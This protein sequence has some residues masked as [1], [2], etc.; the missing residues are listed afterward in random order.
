MGH[1][2]RSFVGIAALLTLFGSMAAAAPTVAAETQAGGPAV[3]VACDAGGDLAAALAAAPDG[4]ALRVSGHCIGRFTIDKALDLR[5]ERTGAVLDGGGLGTTLTISAGGDAEVSGVAIKGGSG[6]VTGPAPST[7]RGGGVLVLGRLRLRD[8]EVVQNT[9]AASEVS[10]IST[11]EGAGIWNGGHLELV[12]VRIADNAA[13]AFDNSGGGLWN[14]GD[15]DIRG[16]SV[17]NNVA[18]GYSGGG[19]GVFNQYSGMLRMRQSVIEA[20]QASGRTGGGAGLFNA[21]MATLHRTDVVDNIAAGFAVAGGG[22]RSSGTLNLRRLQLNRN[23]VS[24]EVSGAGGGL[25]TF[26][27]AT[28]TQVTISANVVTTLNSN[29]KPVG[30]G[31]LARDAGSTQLQLVRTTVSGNSPDNCDPSA[32]CPIAG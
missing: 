27:P 31:I 20:N 5:G 14:S 9:L 15:A 6:K 17:K 12:R 2:K 25:I 4:T 1:V 21:G 3:L 30:G 24:S 18:S 10:K 22:V 26:G 19:G 11:A 23:K 13:R 28:L 7:L 8:A 32:I 29:S 16:S